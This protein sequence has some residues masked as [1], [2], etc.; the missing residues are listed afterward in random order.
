MQTDRYARPASLMLALAV[1]IASPIAGCNSGSGTTVEVSP[2]AQ[3]K[4]QDMLN[5]MHKQMETKHKDM[6]KNTGRKGR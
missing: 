3:K 5:N 1:A 4:T 2:E 6:S